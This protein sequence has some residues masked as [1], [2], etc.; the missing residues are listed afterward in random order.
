[1]VGEINSRECSNSGGLCN[2]VDNL[3]SHK[4]E[5]SKALDLGWLKYS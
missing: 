5:G 1:M 3:E 4:S 2:G